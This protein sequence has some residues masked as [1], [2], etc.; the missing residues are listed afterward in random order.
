MATNLG[1]KQAMSFF[2]IAGSG[3]AK[4]L[5]AVTVSLHPGAAHHSSHFT[6]VKGGDSLS[7]I[8]QRE[9]G[10]AA[11][12]PA[13]WWANRHTVHNPALVQAGQ[14]LRVPGKHQ[15]KPWLERA[16]LAAIP[17]AAPAL[18]APVATT[19]ET[20]TAAP[21]PAAASYGGAPGSFQACVIQAE[22]G[23][24]PTAVNPS[25]GAGGLYQFLP[26]TW[27][28]LGFSGLPE[29]A[30]VA[31]QNAAF[32]KEYAESGTSAWAAYDGC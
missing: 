11:D 16:A 28:A 15:V 25:S 6:T 26:S 3:A 24:N 32:A 4:T 1:G 20:S 29:N 21:A 7:A 14:R 27:Q 8:S 2:S 23:G 17:A 31:E 19:A 13:L 22:S 30:S 10:R 9:F 5:I 12:W 18:A